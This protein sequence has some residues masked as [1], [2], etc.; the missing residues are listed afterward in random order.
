MDGEC[1]NCGLFELGEVYRHAGQSDSAM[2]YYSRAI[3]A[4]GPWR[5]YY[6]AWNLA[7]S[8]QRLGELYDKKGDR[9]AAIGA[10]E[11]LLDLWSNADAELQPIIQ[12]TH[13]RIARL[14]SEH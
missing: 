1:P 6:D 7:A 13:A 10:Y 3:D 8:Y 4:P 12:D 9:Q 2:A 11:R 14:S 5:V